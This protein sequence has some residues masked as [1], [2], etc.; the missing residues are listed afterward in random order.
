MAKKVLVVDDAAVVRQVVSC[1]LTIA[2]YTVIQAVDG[3]DALTKLRA[4][5]IS[6]VITDV[7]MPGMGGIEFIR[8]LR[9]HSEF[10]FMPVVMLTT[11]SH[12]SK[13]QE[14]KEAGAS[15]WL[16]KPFT[17]AQLIDTVRKFVHE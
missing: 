9:N 2:G 15:G 13:M 8:W 5:A 6:M 10:R 11:L 12:E 7:N 14:G 17:A 4:D 3:N 1:M 16:T